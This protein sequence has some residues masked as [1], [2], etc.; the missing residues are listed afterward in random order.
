M[1]ADLGQGGALRLERVC[2]RFGKTQVLSDV[3]LNVAE[4]EFVCILGP[5]GCGKSTL[6][7]IIAGLE[8]QSSGSLHKDG[9][10][11]SKLQPAKRD[12]G[13]LFQSYAL[14]PNLTVEENIAYGLVNRRIKRQELERCVSEL[15]ALVELPGMG[16]RLPVQLSGGE[17]Q[18]V[19]LA[20]ALAPQPR[21]LLL[22]EPLSALDARV[23]SHLRQQITGLQRKLKLMTIMVTH[24]QVEALTMADRVVVMNR[25]VIEQIGTPTDI[26]HRPA[27]RFVAD[28][29]GKMNFIEA[30]GFGGGAFEAAAVKLQVSA[31]AVEAGN[32]VL[33]FRPEEVIFRSSPD[34]ANSWPARVTEVEFLGTAW[35][36][37]LDCPD[38][39]HRDIL[40]DFSTKDGRQFPLQAGQDV[41]VAV[42]AERLHVFGSSPVGGSGHT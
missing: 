5:S 28:F 13:I 20:R 16:A 39:G 21:L 29:V 2:K 36:A 18:R 23:R 40:A 8:Q 4:Q 34:K 12:V 33:G 30:R 27:T 41:F 9:R 14:F 17:Q 35:R 19:A 7:R 31:P 11:I 37:V 10:E 24:D 6:L 25:G 42:P 15:L 32:V 38:L 26:Y 1:F 22:D 3:N